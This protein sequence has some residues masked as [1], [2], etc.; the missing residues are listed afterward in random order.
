MQHP[1]YRAILHIQYVCQTPVV[2]RG[3]DDIRVSRD[4]ASR[5]SLVSRWKLG[6][7]LGHIAIPQEYSSSEQGYTLRNEAGLSYSKAIPYPMK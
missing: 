5:I 7:I 6:A 1:R 4:R 3:R 2:Q